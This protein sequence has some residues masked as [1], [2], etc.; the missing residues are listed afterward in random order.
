MHRDVNTRDSLIKTNTTFNEIVVIKHDKLLS[1]N[2]NPFIIIYS[3]KCTAVVLQ[4]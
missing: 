2:C 3:L 4:N 1:A